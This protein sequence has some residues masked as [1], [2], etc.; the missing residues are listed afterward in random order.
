M[1]AEKIIVSGRPDLTTIL[2]GIG[3]AYGLAFTI[4]GAIYNAWNYI[5]DFLEKRRKK[6]EAA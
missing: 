4:L 1:S 2:G 6:K 3:G 5:S